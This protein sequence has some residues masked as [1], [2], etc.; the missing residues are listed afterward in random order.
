[1]K[2]SNER[3]LEKIQ[4][5]YDGFLDGNFRE[6]YDYCLNDAP[7]SFMYINID[8]NPVEA[9]LR[10]ER[11]IY[12]PEGGGKKDKKLGEKGNKLGLGKA[13]QEEDLSDIK[14][15]HYK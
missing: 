10:F 13:E 12:P 3:E 14:N 11:K 9:Y 4:E 1:M 8:S 15:R 2:V 7:Y 5:E 6:L